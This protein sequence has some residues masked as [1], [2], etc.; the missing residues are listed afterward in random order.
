M[1]SVLLM[2]AVLELTFVVVLD[3][4]SIV[5][6]GPGGYPRLARIFLAMT[7]ISVIFFFVLARLLPV[8]ATEEGIIASINGYGKKGIVKW[9][10]IRSIGYWSRY[11]ILL[12]EI[13]RG[14]KSIAYRSVPLDDLSELSAFVSRYAGSTNPFARWLA[15]GGKDA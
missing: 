15:S 8:E 14:D 6:S 13:T 1:G 9:D 2:F 3:T 12:L 5:S 11:P 4:P 10:D 7:F